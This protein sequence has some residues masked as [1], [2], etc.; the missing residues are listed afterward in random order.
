MGRWVTAG[1]VVWPSRASRPRAGIA[2]AA[3]AVPS[4][5][6]SILRSNSSEL[7]QVYSQCDADPIKCKNGGQFLGGF[8]APRGGRQ[9][10]TIS[11]Q[12]WSPGSGVD[13][14]KSWAPVVQGR[15]GPKYLAIADA[16]AAD[17]AAGR[18]AHG[19]R[20]PPQRDLAGRLA[21]D[22]TTVARGYVE[23]GKRGLV[24]SVVGR[25]PSFGDTPRFEATP[26]RSAPAPTLP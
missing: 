25:G 20:L 11:S 2:L 6:R 3:K 15:E 7:R 9:R 5:V 18:L 8:G 12:L 17:V 26:A 22:F 10:S 14:M 16:I 1:I 24:E 21:L 23:A 19:D 13:A 4:F